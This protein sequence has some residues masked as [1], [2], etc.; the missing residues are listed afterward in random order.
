[1]Y[2]LFIAFYIFNIQEKGIVGKW[3]TEKDLRLKVT[4]KTSS[5]EGL[6]LKSESIPDV[7]QDVKP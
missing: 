3:Y 6:Y 7:H 4:L 5:F 2:T 1:M